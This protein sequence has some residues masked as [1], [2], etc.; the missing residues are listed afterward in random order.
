[1]MPSPPLGPV[2]Q[3]FFVEHLLTHKNASPRT[4]ASYR[5]AFRLLLTFLRETTGTEPCA[6]RLADLDAPAIL[7]F[8]NR[9]GRGERDWWP[10]RD[11]RW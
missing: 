6:M 4:A 5:D 9:N 8:L 2:L 7:E 1:M 11:I 3:A 10:L